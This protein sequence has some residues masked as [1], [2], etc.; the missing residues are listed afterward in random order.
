MGLELLRK[1]LSNG[2]S[3]I[4]RKSME[5]LDEDPRKPSA[6]RGAGAPTRGSARRYLLATSLSGTGNAH[7]GI[8]SAYVL[9]RLSRRTFL[10]DHPGLQRA[11]DGE[12]FEP[13]QRSMPPGLLRHARNSTVLVIDQITMSEA[14]ASPEAKYLMEAD[15]A[16]DP[17][18]V[19]AVITN[20]WFAPLL[21]NSRHHRAELRRMLDLT[22][23]PPA[24]LRTFGRLAR[25]LFVPSNELAQ[26]IA[27]SLTPLGGGCDAGLHVRLTTNTFAE[28]QGHINGVVVKGLRCVQP[29]LTHHGATL[30]LSS[31]YARAHALAANVTTGRGVR[32]AGTHPSSATDRQRFDAKA[33]LD[34]CADIWALSRCKALVVGHY[35]TFGRAAALLSSSTDVVF[36]ER[37]GR[38]PTLDPCFHSLGAFVRTDTACGGNASAMPRSVW[39]PFVSACETK[40]R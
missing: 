36:Y 31:M 26:R 8:L 10:V 22:D 17:T 28:A 24:P 14:W 18:R 33:T 32:V 7:L 20:Q 34:A 19:L 35:S 16:A 1:R 25:E 37:C 12:P 13:W 27:A 6:K 39:R 40:L 11:Y 23:T 9:A 4:Q 29:R 2:T 15:L 21:Y 3:S 38:P 5:W 30:Y